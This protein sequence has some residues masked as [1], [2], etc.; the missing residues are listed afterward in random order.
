[1]KSQ[2]L[3]R[4]ICRITL[5]LLLSTAPATGA[6]L[7]LQDLIP[8]TKYYF[9]DFNPALKP[10]TPGEFRN[11]EE[12]FKNYQYVEIVLH[13]D[14]RAMTVKQYTQGVPKDVTRYRILPDGVLQKEP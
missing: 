13:A 12:V 7:L 1:M 11:I 3:I 2:N 5:I 8:G 14:S 9:D 4:V 10:W 6:E